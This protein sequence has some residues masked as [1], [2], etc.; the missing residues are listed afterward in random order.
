MLQVTT[1]LLSLFPKTSRIDLICAAALKVKPD[2]IHAQ[3]GHAHLY[4]VQLEIKYYWGRNT[5]QLQATG[6]QA[7][8]LRMQLLL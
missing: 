1:D 8:K 3:S 5:V 4:N 7:L 2:K 6:I